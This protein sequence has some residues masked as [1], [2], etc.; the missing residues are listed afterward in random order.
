M[1]GYIQEILADPKGV[2]LIF[3]LALPG[4]LLAIS[5]HESA[6][7]WVA[8]RC[9]D[10]TARLMGRISLN[11]L[12]HLDPVGLLMMVLFGFGWA[13]P[14]PVNPYR[15]QGDRR[16]ADLAVSLAG[17]TVNLILF[18]LFTYLAAL[19]SAFM[20]RADVVREVGLST[21]VSYRYNA[22][23]SVISGT[24]AE[25]FGDLIAVRWL[26]PFVRLFAY[27]ALVNL[28]LAVFNLLPLPPLDGYHVFNDIVFK[29]RFH[30][31]PQAFRIGMLVVLVLSAQGILG[32]IISAAVYPAQAAVLWPVRAIWG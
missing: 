15:F 23:W 13:K 24:A 22:V 26:V 18:L 11:P 16:K 3:L 27:T 32:R 7:A 17:I 14:V 1:F 8:N 2:L 30:L 29:G 9:G 10:P 12:K 25:D 31:S 4:R 20:W 28:N 21:L 6:H 5:A 19:C